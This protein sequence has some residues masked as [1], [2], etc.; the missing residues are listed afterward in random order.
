MHGNVN[1]REGGRAGGR[2]GGRVAGWEREKEAAR[3]RIREDERGKEG[4]TM[5]ELL[6]P[7]SSAVATTLATH[8]AAGRP[9]EFRRLPVAIL[10]AV[11][12][13]CM[14]DRQRQQDF[15][16]GAGGSAGGIGIAAEVSQVVVDGLELLMMD[17]GYVAT[18]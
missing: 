7:P 3:K 17:S 9:V 10:R 13:V 18:K 14:D 16:S 12:T 2:K 4:G 11:H 6:A 8:L 5:T 15:L 1:W